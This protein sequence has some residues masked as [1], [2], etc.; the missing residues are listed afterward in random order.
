MASTVYETEISSGEIHVYG[1]I[2]R[3]TIVP[4]LPKRCT[5]Y[6]NKLTF[7]KLSMYSVLFEYVQGRAVLFL[8]AEQHENLCC[9][10]EC[11][12]PSSYVKCLKHV[13]FKYE[14]N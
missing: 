6:E 3:L 2:L 7:V 12:A 14:L 5:H 9:T 11:F 10:P 1:L 4:H 8:M 13:S